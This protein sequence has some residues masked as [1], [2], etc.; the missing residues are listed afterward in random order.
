MGDEIEPLQSSEILASVDLVARDDPRGNSPGEV[1][2]ET[3]VHCG[4]P[5]TYE[6]PVDD[7][8]PL[9]RHRMASTGNRCFGLM[10]A[11][12]LEPLTGHRYGRARFAVELEDRRASAVR[13]DTDGGST[14]F[15][16]GIGATFP[17]SRL[18]AGLAAAAD[19]QRSGWL[20][21][22]QAR[23]DR[24]AP[25]TTGVQSHT[26][27]WT[28]PEATGDPLHYGM[29]AIVEAPGDLTRLR[30]SLD[31]RV[32][33][34]R[35]LWTRQ[36]RTEGTLRE[37]VHFAEPLLAAPDRAETPAV[38]L[39]MAAD[40]KAYSKQPT[41]TADRT[42]TRLIDILAEARLRAGIDPST[43]R[44]Q[45]QGDGQFTVLP[46]GI[47][48][49]AVIPRLVRGI[50]DGLRETNRDLDGTAR[51][52]LRVALHRGLMW[53][54]DNGWLGKAAIAVHRILD[55]A[56]LRDALDSHPSAD[57]ALAVPDFL[58]RDVIADSYDWLDAGDFSRVD[59]EIPG[60]DFAETAWL[61]VGH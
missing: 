15:V 53:P 52:R 59:V 43:V 6:I 47:D 12:D 13:L 61:Y 44:P 34:V 54:G 16:Y 28:Y 22:L 19:A 14:G 50:E 10:L 21:R 5:L 45:P 33:I 60:K 25:A 27:A 26:F 7:L 58:Y 24:P 11:F 2:R 49:S 31:S 17:A 23:R 57:L 42:Q 20:G 3:T 18:A 39:C 9:L 40:V 48:E 30:G 32:E 36:S 1:I 55:S 46:V 29:H 4:R 35:T 51:L 37:V 8:P 38:R 41:M 56:P